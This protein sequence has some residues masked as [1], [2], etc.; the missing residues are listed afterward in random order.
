MDSWPIDLPQV[1]IANGFAE[2]QPDIALRS[3][4]GVGPAKVRPLTTE[5]VTQLTCPF[6]LTSAQRASLLTFWK[7]TLTSGSLP[8]TWAHPITGSPITCRI[9]SAPEFQPTARG[10]YWTTVLSVEI[11]P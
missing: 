4:M 6:R 8:Y 9:A 1:P 2:K 3:Q 5:G 10:L 11:L 7:T